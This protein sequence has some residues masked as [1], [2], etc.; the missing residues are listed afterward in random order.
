MAETI[1]DIESAVLTV[2][3]NNLKEEFKDFKIESRESFKEVKTAIS[4]LSFVPTAVYEAD[5]K[6]T[7]ERLRNLE[8]EVR[9]FRRLVL[10]VVILAV[11][12]QVI[13]NSG[14]L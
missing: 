9:W 7:D 1:T 10:G 11:I 2:E 8:S 12:G 6:S 13:Y 5:R 4:L 14:R 3:I